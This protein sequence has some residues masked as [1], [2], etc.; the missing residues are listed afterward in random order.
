M[1]QIEEKEKS[2]I[3]EFKENSSSLDKEVNIII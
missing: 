1:D 2:E 3:N